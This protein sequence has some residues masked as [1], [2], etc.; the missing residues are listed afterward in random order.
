[1]SEQKKRK[2]AI[3]GGGVGA[4]TSAFYLASQP[5][6]AEKY[7]ITVYSIVCRLGGKCATGRNPVFGNRIEEHGIHGFLGSYYNTL[8]MMAS[9]YDR[10]GR[11]PRSD[12]HTS[13]LQSLMRTSYA[14]VCMKTKN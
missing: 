6:A 12:E 11:Q 8:S 14:V 7:E 4:L 10:L 13:E 5:G 1:M 9:A 2:I 3:L